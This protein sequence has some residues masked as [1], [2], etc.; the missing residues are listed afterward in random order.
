M[1]RIVFA[2]SVVLWATP[3]FA[4]SKLTRSVPADKAEVAA[5]PPELV[6]TFAEA[7]TLTSV[8]LQPS[9][10]TKIVLSRLPEK[11]IK[12]A[13]VSLP[14]LAAARY[15]VQWRATSEDGHV[16]NGEFSFVVSK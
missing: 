8:K 3:A 9:A 16:I 5:A 4:H 13:H 11:P 2:L 7:V 1:S 6:L 15:T 14:A 12:E 10:G